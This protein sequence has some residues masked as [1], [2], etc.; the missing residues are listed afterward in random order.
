MS[1]A[2]LRARS[3]KGVAA[4][5][6]DEAALVDASRT[7]AAEKIAAYIERVVSTAPP[8]TPDQRSRLTALLT[9]EAA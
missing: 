7:L 9:S 3:L 1:N 2:V 6:G 5:R 8:L 4:R